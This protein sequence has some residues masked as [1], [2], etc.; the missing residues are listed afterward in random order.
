MYPH[1]RHRQPDS[2]RA[3]TPG[4]RP[5]PAAA[6]V[7]TDAIT[8]A[9][10]DEWRETLRR[11]HATPALCLAI[12]HDH[13]SGEIHLCIPDDPM[14]DTTTLIGFLRRALRELDAGR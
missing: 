6:P 11:A 5:P 13:A 9:R 12:G 8:A 10:F 14:W 7:P 1:G 2:F 3:E 4:R